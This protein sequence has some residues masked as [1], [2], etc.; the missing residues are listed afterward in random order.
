MKKLLLL[1]LCVPLIGFGQEF[2]YGD[3]WN[4]AE[5]GV[6]F[7]ITNSG[8]YILLGTTEYYG[9]GLKDI[10][11]VKIDANGTV[12]WERTYGG[13]DQDEGFAVE[14]TN[15]NG[16][17]LVGSTMSFA[18]G[19]VDVILIKTGFYGDSLWSKTFTGISNPSFHNFSLKGYD[20]KQTSDDGYLISGSYAAMPVGG[21]NND[22]KLFL[23][24]TDSNGTEQWRKLYDGETAYDLHLSNNGNF[25]LTGYTIDAELILMKINSIGDSIW[26]KNYGSV[27]GTGSSDFAFGYS[28]E[29]TTD[30][31]FILC[32]LG[33]A[34]SLNPIYG[35][36]ILKTDSLGNEEWYKFYTDGDG[37]A[38]S[39]QQTLD[40]GYIVVGEKSTN[41]PSSY[42]LYLVKMDNLGNIQWEK[43]FGG[44]YHDKGFSVQ[45]LMNG[46]YV[47]F[48]LN[49]YTSLNHRNA[50]LIMTDDQGNISSTFN[51][52]I[53]PNRELEKVVDIL[54]KDI[55]PV[56][57][58]PF[59][60][61]YNDGTVEKKIIIE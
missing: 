8:D 26:S 60:E 48:G 29:T 9:N 12:L 7:Q 24:K 13:S 25:V 37:R 2:L 19:S 36:I 49:T 57:N 10:Y 41:S 38:Y 14:V 58:K 40:G 39:I 17:I 51:I 42:D 16:Y 55:N 4:G 30:G 6:D 54:G 28:I 59:I 34:Y 56:K 22:Y 31:G 21:G 3:D 47:M 15:D 46:S 18:S 52:P 11:L 53:N 45:Q 20:V 44:S 43:T 27:F 23:I 5:V 50:Y 35:M 32:G 61:I 1:L 33:C